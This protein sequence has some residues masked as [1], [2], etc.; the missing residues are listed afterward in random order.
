MFTPRSSRPPRRRL[1]I[2]A[3]PILLLVLGGL[4]VSRTAAIA[5]PASGSSTS[6]SSSSA[7]SKAEAKRIKRQKKL[8]KK[9]IRFTNRTRKKYG[10]SK[11]KRSKALMK[12]AQKHS[13]VQS[14]NQTQGHQF[15]GEDDLGT[16]IT[17]AGFTNW[18]SVG[19]N[20]AGATGGV[21]FVNAH[22]VMYGGTYTKDSTTY[23][24]VGWMEDE[25]HKDNII[26]CDFTNI[27]VGAYIDDDGTIWWTQDFA[28]KS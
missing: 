12:A 22:D 4:L 27:G 10:C 1:W 11:V 23:T 6:A 7:A 25:G 5:S 15:D 24:S 18:S 3:V 17:K 8:R 26:N 19:E 2:V 13:K 14:D 9:V 21:W 16:R 28:A 20:A